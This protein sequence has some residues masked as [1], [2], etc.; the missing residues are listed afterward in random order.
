MNK[1]GRSLISTRLINT[2]ICVLNV[3]IEITTITIS[4][5]EGE[6]RKNKLFLCIVCIVF[7]RFLL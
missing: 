3:Y 7:S 2:N 5:Y 4:F 6:V 1:N